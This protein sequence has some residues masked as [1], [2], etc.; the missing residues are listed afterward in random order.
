M[1]KTLR[2]GSSRDYP[3]ASLRG[4]PRAE[5]PRAEAPR[6]EAPRAERL[7]PMRA[8][9]IPTTL[10][11][12][13]SCSR[14]SRMSCRAATAPRRC[15]RRRTRV[16]MVGRESISATSKGAL[17]RAAASAALAASAASAV[18]ALGF[19]R[20]RARRSRWRDSNLMR[21]LR[22]SSARIGPR[23]GGASSRR[24]RPTRRRTLTMARSARA[25]SLRRR[26]RT[27]ARALTTVRAVRA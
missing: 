21:K 2:S 26:R 4:R 16:R 15:K 9:T 10:R 7:P 25:A 5:A 18:L 11:R 14:S 27:T 23:S 24:R 13:T 20:V 1:P 17:Q 22:R 19:R 3:L 8:K 12:R 6:A